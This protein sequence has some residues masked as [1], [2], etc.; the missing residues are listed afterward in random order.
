MSKVEFA[1]NMNQ[2]ITKNEKEMKKIIENQTERFK[3]LLLGRIINN[4][5]DKYFSKDTLDELFDSIFKN[6][7]LEEIE[8]LI[9]KYQESEI[10]FYAGHFK[11]VDLIFNTL[12]DKR[13][14]T[15]YLENVMKKINENQTIIPKDIFS[16]SCVQGNF[17]I[18]NLFSK[19]I[20]EIIKNPKLS[21][22]DADNLCDLANKYYTNYKND[23]LISINTFID[24]NWRYAITMIETEMDLKDLRNGK[25]S[26]ESRMEKEITINA[27]KRMDGI[28]EKIMDTYNIAAKK[29]LQICSKKVVDLIFDYLPHEYQDQ[30]GLLEVIVDTNIQERL[31]NYLQGE[32]EKVEENVK[33]Q[34]KDI[35]SNELYDEKR[36]KTIEDYEI[37]LNEINDIYSNVLYEIAIA[38]DIPQEEWTYKKILYAINN[39]AINSKE[40]FLKLL[41]Y[42]RYENKK[43]IE[44]V[45]Y[46]MHNSS[47][48]AYNGSIKTDSIK[49]R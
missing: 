28:L 30:R 46:D 27:I 10:N 2:E 29:Q 5:G 11:T 4:E 43:R 16:K 3:K 8:Q 26:A 31:G 24:N 48:I 21:L 40:T 9:N 32:S 33:K 13:T 20:N 14:Q 45:V 49:L 18:D 42:I 37:T 6:G 17:S 22:D 44:F 36:Y 1:V 39:E 15:I 41:N 19:F 12:N 38:Y 34:N 35:L 7:L 47:K 25:S 23:F